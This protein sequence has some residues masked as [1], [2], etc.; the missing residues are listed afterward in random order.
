M[1]D[2][3]I[4]WVTWLSGGAAILVLIATAVILASPKRGSNG[5][6]G[7]SPR[8]SSSAAASPM[9]AA[10]S[11]AAQALARHHP[12]DISAALTDARTRAGLSFD[13][14]ALIGI[15]VIIEGAKPLGPVEITYAKAQ[16]RPVPGAPVTSKRLRISY[17]GPHATQ[18]EDSDRSVARA[19]PDPNCPLEAAFRA[20]LAAGGP[21]DA[22]YFA[23][24]AHSA[25]HERATWTL[26]AGSGGAHHVDGDSCAL[27]RR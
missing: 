22:R 11:A 8:A 15:R 27:L 13:G 9:D 19:L 1:S 23:V 4:P 5:A 16:G 26:T 25:R 20:T 7:E 3:R 10:P 24:Y 18:A 17:D 2:D 6:S 14:A 12:L 21:A